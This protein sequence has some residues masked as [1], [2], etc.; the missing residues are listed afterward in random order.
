MKRSLNTAIVW[1]PNG[2]PPDDHSYFYVSYYRSEAGS[3]LTDRNTGSVTA[4]LAE[5]FA[6]E[7]AVLHLQME[8]IYQSAF[9]ELATGSS[10]DHVVALPADAVLLLPESDL[11]W[12]EVQDHLGD[13]KI[14]VATQDLAQREKL[15]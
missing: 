4:T 13:C 6:R 1:K 5:A 15:K 2:R 7:L 14:L 11:D 3:D 10:L 8:R 12:N 9:V